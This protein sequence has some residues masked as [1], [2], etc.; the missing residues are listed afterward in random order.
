[1]RK[2]IT[3]QKFFPFSQLFKDSINDIE[4]ITIQK[5][6]VNES[7]TEMIRTDESGV[8]LIKIEELERL[9][10]EFSNRTTVVEGYTIVGN[11]L[12][13]LPIGSKLDSKEKKFYWQPGCGFIGNYRFMFIERNE[14]N[15]IRKTNITVRIKPKFSNIE[16]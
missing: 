4:P 15:Q 16:Q 10:V 7:E 8:F 3:E 12:K 6:I 1:M 5:G 9:I 11:Q 13:P 14:D 2:G